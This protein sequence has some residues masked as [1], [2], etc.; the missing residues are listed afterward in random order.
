M[1]SGLLAILGGVVAHQTDRVFIELQASGTPRGWIN[2]SR[3]GVGVLTIIAAIG[4]IAPRT[5]RSVVMLYTLAAAVLVGVGVA[6][7]YWLDFLNDKE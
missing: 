1:I 2:M 3:A 4:M 7:G 5:A 6:I